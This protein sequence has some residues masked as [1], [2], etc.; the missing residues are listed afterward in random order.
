MSLLL[1]SAVSSINKT[2]EA[3]SKSIIFQ[4]TTL[5]FISKCYLGTRTMAY[6]LLQRLHVHFQAPK[7]LSLSWVPNGGDVMKATQ[8]YHLFRVYSLFLAMTGCYHSFSL[9]CSSGNPK[10]SAN[11][12]H[13][14]LSVFGLGAIFVQSDSR[15]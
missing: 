6:H 2:A 14:P 11:I 1:L 3:Y 5:V 13:K 15:F 8:S 7:E 10:S 12:L 9:L 4:K